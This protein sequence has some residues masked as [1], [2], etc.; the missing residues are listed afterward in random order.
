MKD[1]GLCRFTGRDK[2]HA[3]SCKPASSS[4]DH[5][6]FGGGSVG[7]TVRS[8]E[9]EEEIDLSKAM[10]DDPIVGIDKIISDQHGPGS[11]AAKSLP[12]PKPMSAAE[13]EE[14]D[15]THIKF[16]PGCGICQ[17]TRGV[18]AQH[19]CVKE[20]LRAIPL[21]VADCCFLRYANSDV[22]RTVPVMRLYR[23]RFSGLLYPSEGIRS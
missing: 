6:A 22:L 15:L 1:L 13:K 16:H 10:L 11:L 21:L 18:N 3:S 9:A 4:S 23:Y 8:E 17:A 12:T 7:Q 19:R 5:L 20:Q 2:L 14:H